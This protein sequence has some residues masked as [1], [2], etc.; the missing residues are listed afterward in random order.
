MA[1]RHKYVLV[2]LFLYR[3]LW[4]FFLYRF[5]DSLVSPILARFP[6]DH[7]DPNALRLF[8]I[9]AQFRLLKTDIAHETLWLL[10]GLFLIRMAIT[11]LVNAGLYYSFY[12]SDEGQGTRV[13]SGIRRRWKPVALLYALEN[14]L[15]LLPAVW[16]APMAKA[17]FFA[18][19]SLQDWLRAMLPYLLAWAAW[20]FAVHLASQFMQFGAASGRGILQGLLRAFRVALPLCGVSLAIIGLGAAASLVVT[21]AALLWTGFF[22]VALHQG[23]QLV[24]SLIALWTSASQYEL[25]KPESAG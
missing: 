18:D 9:E 4:G 7:P 15:L 19:P 25:W 3:L 16:I 8:L 23:F 1:L 10:A 6:D 2:V 13:L 21:T 5:V 11:P 17:L 14:V 22:A 12:H 24:R 20:G